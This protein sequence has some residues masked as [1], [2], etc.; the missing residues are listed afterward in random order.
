M[1]RLA[2]PTREM[3]QRLRHSLLLQKTQVRFPGA[4]VAHNSNFS[5]RGSNTLSGLPGYKAHMIHLNIC[6]QNIHTHNI[7]ILPFLK[8]AILRNN[9]EVSF[10][11]PTAQ[12]TSRHTHLPHINTHPRGTHA[13]TLFFERIF[14]KIENYSSFIL[15]LFLNV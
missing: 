6:K 14:F 2:R 1:C 9:S 10:W 5:S 15:L 8:V 12:C 7:E 11:P 4:G 13:H 3:A